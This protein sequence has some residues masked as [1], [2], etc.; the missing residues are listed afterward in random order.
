MFQVIEYQF[1]SWKEE[2]SASQREKRLLESPSHHVVEK[3]F[4]KLF[5]A[6]NFDL[7]NLLMS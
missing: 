2:R 1:D 7:D 4:T 3:I 5:V 6:L